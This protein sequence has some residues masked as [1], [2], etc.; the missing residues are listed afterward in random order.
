MGT[1]LGALDTALGGA[2]LLVAF[3]ADEE[4]LSPSQIAVAPAPLALLVGVNF[5]HSAPP[6]EQRFD[7]VYEVG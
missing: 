3:A 2:A 5:E 7:Y 4:D 1:L 6:V